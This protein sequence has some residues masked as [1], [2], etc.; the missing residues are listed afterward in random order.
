MPKKQTISRRHQPLGLTILYEDRDILVVDKAAGLLTIS[1]QKGETTTAYYRLTDY[2]R[3]GYAKSRNR[4]FIVHRLDRDVSGLLIFAKTAQAKE[5]LQERWEGFDKKY[6]AVVHG[7]LKEKTG[8]ISSYLAENAAHV[9]YSTPD[10]EKGKL[11]Y[12]GYRVLKET[13]A[14]SLLEIDLI[15]G[16]KNQIRVHLAEKGHPIVGDKKYGEKDPRHRRLALHARRLTFK[17]PFSE[18]EMTFEARVPGYISG[19]VGGMGGT[20]RPPNDAGT[21]S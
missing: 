13:D 16:R 14:F 6:V 3:K 18:K 17:H 21:V 20:T 1:T 2:V 12:T 10:E 19:L 11:A 7:T 9:V 4:I 15:T 8:I 5:F